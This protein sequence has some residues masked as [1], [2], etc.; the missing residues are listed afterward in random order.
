MGATPCDCDSGQ[1]PNEKL[2][3]SSRAEEEQNSKDLINQHTVQQRASGAELGRQKRAAAP[4][5]RKGPNDAEAD[6]TYQ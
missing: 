3:C 4:D 2:L 6:Q 5:H 1:L